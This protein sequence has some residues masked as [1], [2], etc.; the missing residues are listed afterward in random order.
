MTAAAKHEVDL[1]H[2]SILK[3]LLIVAIPLV[4][5]NI[6]QLLFNAADVAIVGIFVGDDAVA[7]VG[8]NTSLIN[9]IIGLFVGLAAGVSVVLAKYVGQG[10]VKRSNQLVGTAILMSLIIGF[11]LLFVGVFGARTFLTWMNC[12][13]EILDGA[14]LY[15]KIYCMGMPIIML[16]NFAAGILRAVGDT[17]RPMLFLMLGGVINVGLNV[18]FVVVCDM[19]VDGV[20]IATVASQAVSAVLSMIVMFK[21][22]GYSRF[23][24]KHFRI[25][26]AELVEIIRVGLPSGIQACMFN[27]SNV[28]IQSTVNSFLKVGTTANAVAHQFDAFVAMTGNGIALANMSLVSQNYGAMKIKRV[29]RSI[30]TSLIVTLIASLSVGIIVMLLAEPLCRIMTQDVNVIEM[31]K[32]RMNIMCCTFFIGGMM[33]TLTYSLRSLGKSTT[34]MIISIVFVCVFRVLWLNT[35]YLLNPTF[36]MIFYSY[37]ISWAMSII[38]DLMFLLPTI[39]KIEKAAA[40]A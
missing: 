10:D 38:V 19:T 29:K 15:L 16:Y 35:F 12:D 31:A 4:L 28:L 39:K 23:S 5:T 3:K 18:F 2:G 7:A 21:S 34:A 40:N 22:K 17:L 27:V 9:L 6:L 13:P 36:A 8:A 33:D 24:V 26:K 11:V 30:W 37:P 14:A 25:Y 20:A 1:T 32:I